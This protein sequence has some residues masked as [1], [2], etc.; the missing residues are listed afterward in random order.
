MTMDRDDNEGAGLG[1]PGLGTLEALPVDL[2]VG[3]VGGL[4]RLRG[5]TGMRRDAR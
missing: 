3:P 1:R 5:L 2:T 4:E